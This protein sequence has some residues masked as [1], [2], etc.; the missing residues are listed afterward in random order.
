MKRLFAVLVALVASSSSF[1]QDFPNRPLTWVVPYPAGGIT[2]NGARTIAKIMSEQLG[3]PVIIENKPGA[4]GIVGA[5]YVANS[6]KDGYTFLY[7]A[8]G[9]V[10]YPFLFKKLSYDPAKDFIPVHGLQSASMLIMVRADSPFKSLDDLIAYAKKNPGK[11]NYGTV[12]TG[13]VQHLFGEILQKEAGF[14]MTAVPY[15]GSAPA[16]TDLLAGV[17]D[18]ALDFAVTMKPQIEGGKLRALAVSGNERLTVLPDVK[19]MSD[20]GYPGAAFTAWSAVVLPAGTPQP[21][22][23]KLAKSIGD[24]LDKPEIIKYFNDQGAGNLRGMSKEKLAAFFEAERAKMKAIVER[25][26]IQA[27]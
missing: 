16:L 17:I 25:S 21:I 7:T 12:G 5:E 9:I 6:K 18:I 8:N 2:D 15:K 27:E 23:D 11:L 1:A 3:Q 4:G 14:Q 22:V 10:T 24:A 19:S 26:G 20:Y 13:S